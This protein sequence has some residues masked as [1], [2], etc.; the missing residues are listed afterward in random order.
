M[1]IQFTVAIALVL[2][3]VTSAQAADPYGYRAPYTVEQPLNGYSWAGPY[4]GGNIGYAWGDVSQN[5]AEPSGLNGG[6]QGGYNWQFGQFVLGGEVDIQASGASDT[7]AAWKFSNPWFGTLRGRAGF[8]MNNIL[9][10]GTGGLAFGSVRAQVLNLTETN[11]TAG[12]TLGAGAEIG[13][14]QNWSVKA[15]YLYVSLN[16]NHFMVTGMPNSYDFSVVRFG[17]NYKF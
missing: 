3:G 17:V 12:W 10:Y 15:E 2:I 8:A 7:F 16:E 14:T 11:T 5:R 1:R 6:V 9:I 13:L 4:V